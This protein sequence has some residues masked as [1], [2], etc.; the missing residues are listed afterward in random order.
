MPEQRNKETPQDSNAEFDA[1]KELARKLVRVL[2]AE[3]DKITLNDH[4]EHDLN[5]A[6]KRS[7]E[8]TR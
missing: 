2:K 4:R 1:F 6:L 8:R 3:I 5:D 7:R